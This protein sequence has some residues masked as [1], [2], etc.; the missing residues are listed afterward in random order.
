M[1][2]HLISKAVLDA[3]VEEQEMSSSMKVIVDAGHFREERIEFRNPRE[4]DDYL[5][6]ERRAFLADVTKL[7]REESFRR[8]I[9]RRHRIREMWSLA[10]NSEYVFVRDYVRHLLDLKN[11]KVF[12]RARYLGLPMDKVAPLLLAG[13]FLEKGKLV[14]QYSQSLSDVSEALHATPYQKVWDHAVDSLTEQDTF[15]DL[16]KNCEDFLMAY[17]RRARRIVFGPEPVFAFILAKLKE[18]EQVRF[19]GMGKLLQIP[20][21]TLRRRIFETYV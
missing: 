21:Q 10:R 13:G 20:V 1:E 16:E 5:D 3:A 11:I 12:L 15:A 7:F 19:I 2:I 18:L 6:V 9:D 14:E 8:L 17:L 4:L